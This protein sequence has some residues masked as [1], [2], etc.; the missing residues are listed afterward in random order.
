MRIIISGGGTGGHIY[1]AL[2]IADT[3]QKIA[4][5]AEIRFV[6]TTHGL[7]K[8]L[9]PRAGYPIDFIDV[10][11]F[12][13]SLSPDTFRSVYKL[14]TGLRDAKRLLDEY[15]P[16]LVIGT[17]GYVCG[18]VVFLAAVKGIPTCVQEQNALPGV[19]NKILSR[20]VKK[21]FLGYKEADKYFAGKAKKIFT[22]NPIREEILNHT[23]TEGLKCFGLD[24]KKKTVLIAGGS[25]GAASINK[26]AFHLEQNLSGRDD[27]QV[28]HATGKN[29]YDAYVKQIEKAG[30]FQSNIHVSPYLYDMPKALAVADLAVF[31]SG[32]IGLAELTAKG[33]PS[34]LVPFPYATANH[35][36][37]NARALEAE[38]AALVILDKDL[39]GDVLQDKVERLLLHEEELEKMKTASKKA[40]RPKA[41]MEIAKQAVALIQ[42]RGIRDSK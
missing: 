15:K 18:P 37:F 7:E 22:G 39:D 24:P 41:A 3:I 25:L 42:N 36:E 9:V 16:H 33:I 10:Q 11:G 40:G 31:R 12:K 17:G 2:T 21:I 4:P 28:L 23:R 35:Q 1:P 5:E 32:A 6:G 38:G 30:G 13:R 19:T 14:F 8:D 20:F 34:I 27:V 26:A 29:N